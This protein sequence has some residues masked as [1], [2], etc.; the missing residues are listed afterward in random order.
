MYASNIQ[1]L[2]KILLSSLSH[3]AEEIMGDHQCGFRHNRSATDHI[4][5]ICHMLYLRKKWEYNEAVYHLFVDIKKAYDSVRRKVLYSIL[6][7]V[8]PWN[9]GG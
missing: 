4:F 1:I 6:S 2:S 9:K 5:C 3:Y 7:F 8:Y